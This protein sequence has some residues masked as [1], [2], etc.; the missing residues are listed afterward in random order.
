VKISQIRTI[1]VDRL[2]S[3]L[4]SAKPEFMGELV[5]GLLDLIGTPVAAAGAGDYSVGGMSNSPESGLNGRQRGRLRRAR[6]N[7][8][9]D[10]RCADSGRLVRAYGLWCW[11]LK[12]PMVW[13]ERPSRY[14]RFGRVRLDMLT[15]PNVLTGKGQELMESLAGEASVSPHDARWE[16]VARARVAAL[17]KDAYRAAV[18]AGNYRLNEVRPVRVNLARMER[19]AAG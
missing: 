10:A 16:R 13:S 2:G 14:S 18:A 12:V 9:L 5:D 3:R 4:A 7:G 11:R 15:T 8:Y 19:A 17:S 1:S 6:E